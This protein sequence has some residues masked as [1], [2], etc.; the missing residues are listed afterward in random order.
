[1][2]TRHKFPCLWGQYKIV[3]VADVYCINKTIKNVKNTK[4]CIKFPCLDL[5]TLQLKWFTDASF[6]NLPNGGSQGGQIIFTTNSNNNLCPV[7]WNSSKIKGVVHS[8]IAV[9]TPPLVDGCD[10]AI[11]IN[12]LLSELLHMESNCLSITVFTENKSLHD[13]VYSMKQTLEKCLLIDISAT[14]EMVKRNEI[15]VTWINTEKQLSDI[16]TKS[17]VLKMTEL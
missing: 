14:W 9:E 1:M 13:V 6:N 12:N 17:G 7:Y 10:V 2:Q 11:Y 4:N 16:L 5:K 3:T 8:T 15:T